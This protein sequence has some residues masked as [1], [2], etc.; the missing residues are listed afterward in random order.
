MPRREVEDVLKLDD[1]PLSDL[2]DLL[3]SSI[4]NIR[5]KKSVPEEKKRRSDFGQKRKPEIP[6]RLQVIGW[7]ARLSPADK[8][9]FRDDV[10]AW[11]MRLYRH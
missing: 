5:E 9:Q 11:W 1:G 8:Q 6:Q 2:D 3:I 4:E 7:Y 10:C